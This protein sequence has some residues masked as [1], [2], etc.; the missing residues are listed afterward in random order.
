MIELKTSLLYGNLDVE[1]D[2]WSIKEKRFRNVSAIFDT[3]AHITHIDTGILKRLG[4][5]LNSAD[6]SYV[7][8]IG[9]RN[10]QINNIVLENIK[11]GDVEL[12]AVLVNFSDMS[13]INF[14]VILGLNIIKEFN[15]NMDFENKLISMKPVFD[16]NYKNN[17]DNFNKN[18]SRFGMWAITKQFE[19]VENEI[20]NI[21]KTL[22][23]WGD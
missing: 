6:K 3:G 17:I 9:S 15:I 8:T 4:Y 11:L 18:N 22:Q 5:D 13:D 14:P 23:K 7:S 1:I 16:V 2:L 12:G 21:Q 10:M 20:K 19:Q